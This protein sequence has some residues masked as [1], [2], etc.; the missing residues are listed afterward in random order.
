MGA[1]GQFID[2]L[3]RAL[4]ADQSARVLR[5]H[6]LAPTSAPRQ[7]FSIQVLRGQHILTRDAKPADAFVTV[8]DTASGSRLFKSRTQL[9]SEDPKWEQSFEFSVSSEPKSLDIVVFDRQLVGRHDIVGSRTIRLDPA[10]FE[11]E[12]TRDLVLPLSPRGI[13][14]LRV[15]AVGR[16]RYDVGYHLTAS[17]RALERTAADMQSEI[18]DRLAEHLR[19]H[20]CQDTL[21]TVTKPLRDRRRGRVALSDA[22]IDASLAP[23]LDYLDENVSACPPRLSSVSFSSVSLF[24]PSSFPPSSFHPSLSLTSVHLSSLTSAL[25]PRLPTLT[26]PTR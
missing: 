20:L 25:P 21:A 7:V 19:T 12:P 9:E 23:V 1:A 5:E 2:D 24:H 17:K 4:E 3:A 14:M 18:V 26:M 15:T 11:S 6:K 13:V 8:T 16:E 10:S 22:E